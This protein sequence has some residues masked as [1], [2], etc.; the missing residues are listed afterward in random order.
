MI[1][2]RMLMAGVC[3]LIATLVAAKQDPDIEKLLRRGRVVE[4]RAACSQ[5]K[6]FA[7]AWN[8]PLLGDWYFQSGDLEKAL[9][10]YDQGFPV[11]GLARTWSGM[12]DRHL[13]R[14]EKDKARDAYGR[15]LQAFETLIRD[16]R[17]SWS[18]L[19]NAERLTVR[20]KWQQLGGQRATDQ[21]QEKL[22]RLLIKAAFYCQQLKEALLRYY[23][24]EEVIE[25]VDFSHAQ[26][27]EIVNLEYRER[28][29]LESGK[30]KATRK[31][32]VFDYQLISEKGAFSEKR[33][34]LL[35]NGRP[36]RLE[37]S[38]ELQ[39]S[40]Y[41]LDKIVYAPIELLGPDQSLFFEYRLLEERTDEAGPLF[42]VEVL[43]LIYP[44]VTIPFGK[45]W[46]RKNGRV[47][48]IELNYKSIQDYE[49]IARKARKRQMV[50]AIS[51][52]VSFEKEH[53]GIGFPSAL[54]LQDAFVDENGTEHVISRVD[55]TYRKYQFFVVE[56]HADLLES[57]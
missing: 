12:A 48:R 21:E 57:N 40:H 33:R 7:A 37:Q 38:T 50:P 35:R 25:T 53:Q 29:L 51:F 31:S 18:W 41:S 52:V 43:P 6:G 23:C 45:A 11:I 14:G 8:W 4:A 17:C 47:E 46:L 15:A 19:W 44:K 5:L 26:A 32:Q 49:K 2:I 3:L 42:V 1:K 56:T 22:Q 34:L 9:E 16:D 27:D 24:E 20:K 30:K 10:Y 39:V 54:R 28:D 36:A 55:I 13:E